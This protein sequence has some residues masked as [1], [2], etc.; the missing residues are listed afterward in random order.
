[1]K[2]RHPEEIA[3]ADQDLPVDAQ[4]TGMLALTSTVLA[5]GCPKSSPTSRGLVIFVEE[6][7]DAVVSLDLGALGWRA[8]GEWP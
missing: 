5:C 6:A 3:E 8:L 7:A 2:H 4:S 1:M